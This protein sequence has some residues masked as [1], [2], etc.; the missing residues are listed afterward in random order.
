MKLRRR[1]RKLEAAGGG[2][3][4][5]TEGTG[6][7]TSSAAVA[8]AAAAALLPD[9][10]VP[11]DALEEAG[12]DAG[13]DASSEGGV[14]GKGAHRSAR[15][16]TRSVAGGSAASGPAL[17]AAEDWLRRRRA[18]AAD[19]LLWPDETD[20]PTQ[21]PARE[22]FQRYRGL[23]SMRSSPW[24]PKESLPT[25]YGRIY[26]LPHF[27]R[28]QARILG[29]SALA[30]RAL[31]TLEMDAAEAARCHKRE[32]AAAAKGK[33]LADRRAASTA[34]SVAGSAVAGVGSGAGAAEIEMGGAMGHDSEGEDE[35]SE[36]DEAGSEGGGMDVDAAGA[37]AGAAGGK[38]Q[39]QRGGKG[40]A[41][42]P[43]SSNSAAIAAAAAGGLPTG[44]SRGVG[45]SSSAASTIGGPA[46]TVA[47][48][49][50]TVAGT[51]GLQEVLGEG[52]VAPG[53]FVCLRLS[54][55]PLSALQDAAASGGCGAPLTL[56]SLLRHEAKASVMHFSLTRTD[57]YGEPI[58]SKEQL[59][60]HVGGHRLFDVRPIYSSGGA[61]S[62]SASGGRGR[63]EKF[64]QGG[65]RVATATA[66]APICYAPCPV[67]AF[68]RIPLDPEV[69]AVG[70]QT[71][72]ASAI[73]RAAGS[74]EG[75]AL[76]SSAA[77]AAGG[78]AALTADEP[79]PLLYPAPDRLNV[80]AACGPRYRLVLVAAGSV[81]GADPDRLVLKRV[82]LTGYP[83]RIKVRSATI[84]YLFFNP[85]DVEY[86]KPVELYTKH[87]LVGNVTEPLGTHGLLKAHFDKPL[88][89]HDTVCMPLYKRVY[90]RWGDCYAAAVGVAPG[91]GAGSGLAR[92]LKGAQSKRGAAA[93]RRAAAAAAAGRALMDGDEEGEE[94]ENDDLD[95]L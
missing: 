43:P 10:Y 58:A 94:E 15:S 87:G 80:A 81:L 7:A 72:T 24:D 6:A 9:G 11:T 52:W 19:E 54:N 77:S 32:T 31:L 65:G 40:K 89:Q 53:A 35:Q 18:A 23:K 86:W 26:G 62:I 21:Q 29:E 30:E 71:V 69:A 51:Q 91:G 46:G 73:A 50:P 4:D 92:G 67:L 2:A 17:S 66:Y 47:T 27:Q 83:T 59:E 39:Q 75:A 74:G 48:A 78:A 84:K 38:K 41:R 68:K 28:A 37:G 93:K 16:A 79:L 36:S 90:P 5:G 61:G 56:F 42:Q 20:T 13:D 82:V 33:R 25:A 57:T 45:G 44:A 3:A 14:S 49:A 22:R 88:K 64:L 1:R 70:G 60:L 63:A 76:P 12:S 55:V 8:A 85:G 34:G 95:E